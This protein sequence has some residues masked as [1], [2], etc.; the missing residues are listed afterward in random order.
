MV[1]RGLRGP[2][3]RWLAVVLK[4]AGVGAVTANGAALEDGGQNYYWT[5]PGRLGPLPMVYRPFHRSRGVVVWTDH[6][7]R[8]VWRAQ[9][10]S[11]WAEPTF[12][13]A[14]LDRLVG[15]TLDVPYR[16]ILDCDY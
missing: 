4:K 16:G 3:S 7:V 1:L 11:I 5:T 15:L 12:E 8:M 10:L 9:G 6:R 2:Q 14:R 13:G